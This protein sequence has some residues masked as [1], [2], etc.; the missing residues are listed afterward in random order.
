MNLK[1][2]LVLILIVNS[3]AANCQDKQYH[4]LQLGAGAGFYSAYPSKETGR[5]DMSDFSGETKPIITALGIIPIKGN[6]SFQT[7]LSVMRKIY[8]FKQL[9]AYPDPEVPKLWGG[10]LNE[11]HLQIP[12]LIRYQ[13]LRKPVVSILGGGAFSFK[14]KDRQSSM[15]DYDSPANVFEA[16]FETGL[17]IQQPITPWVSIFAQ[18]KYDLMLYRNDIHKIN[19]LN[20]SAGL[21]FRLPVS[22]EQASTNDTTVRTRKMD[23][24]DKKPPQLGVIVGALQSFPENRRGATTFSVSMIY[25]FDKFKKLSTETG[26]T[27]YQKSF[28]ATLGWNSYPGGFNS[29][30][31][32]LPLNFVYQPFPKSGFATVIG[33]AGSCVISQRYTKA[34]HTGDFTYEITANAGVQ[35]ELP[36]NNTISFITRAVYEYPLFRNDEFKVQALTGSAGLLFN[37]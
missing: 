15:F 2:L 10:A 14:I 36:L 1:S 33:F 34:L 35:Y 31:L 6:F 29:T 27:I 3:L 30:Y 19:A 8:R 18:S 17:Q 9:V 26:L 22:K 20:G 13:L 11:D 23:G 28:T 24:S 16:S 4:K 37:L 32:K 12:L 7:E 21:I 25:V 5:A